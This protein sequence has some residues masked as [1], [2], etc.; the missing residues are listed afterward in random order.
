MLSRDDLYAEINDNLDLGP[1][2]ADLVEN[3]WREKNPEFCEL[4]DAV[5]ASLS[6]SFW[7]RAEARGA[8]PEDIADTLERFAREREA[9]AKILAEREALREP[10]VVKR[11]VNQIR[12]SAEYRDL[13]RSAGPG[14][15]SIID[16]ALPRYVAGEKL[17]PIYPPRPK[18][19]E[20]LSPSTRTHYERLEKMISKQISFSTDSEPWKAIK[21][22]CG[23]LKSSSAPSTY[24]RHRAVLVKM[25]E[26]MGADAV[27]R[28]LGALPHRSEMVRMLG[29]SQKN[30][31]THTRERRRQKNEPKLSQIFAQ[32]QPDMRDAIRLLRATGARVGE[33]PS[34]R[35][36]DNGDTWKIVFEIEKTG[37]RTKKLTSI[38]REISFKKNSPDGRLAE[39]VIS[40]MGEMPYALWSTSRIQSAWYRARKRAGDDPSSQRFCL[41]AFRHEWAGKM[42][43][44]LSAEWTRRYGKRWWD[45]PALKKAWMS[46]VAERL[47]QSHY[48]SSRVYG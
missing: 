38:H 7:E 45:D 4:I 27:L 15:A 9:K 16:D 40:T 8:S 20:D 48:E 10:D 3:R 43:S 21:Y 1:R 37:S 44:Q 32:L 19:W 42:K 25:A 17:T 46:A 23:V 35:I 33:M 41:H 18:V 6:T 2:V 5:G 36:V 29:I 11:R 34:A 14:V 26:K 28:G 39:N 47:G 30:L 12:Q 13:I 31:G 22:L 24:H